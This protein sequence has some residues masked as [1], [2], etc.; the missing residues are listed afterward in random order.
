[1]ATIHIHLDDD[2]KTAADLLF[3]RLG[4]DTESALKVYLS[5]IINQDG[6]PFPFGNCSTT[7]ESEL[8]FTR[9]RRMNTKGSLRGKVRMADDFDAPL[10]EM[11]EY[12]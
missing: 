3:N 5:T 4:L 11:K 9:K 8:A 1:M 2:T 7:A 10:D 12:M 6:V